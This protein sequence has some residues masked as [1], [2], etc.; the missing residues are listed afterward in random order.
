MGQ[1]NW[2]LVCT[3]SCWDGDSESLKMAT[4]SNVWL[5]EHGAIVEFSDTAIA[6]CKDFYHVF[7]TPT[8]VIISVSLRL[9][10]CILFA[11]E[12]WMIDKM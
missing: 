4:C 12:S 11:T 2:R 8:E 5:N 3:R 10:T 7:I 6:P 9:N 1:Q